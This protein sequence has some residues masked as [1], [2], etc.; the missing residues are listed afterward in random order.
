MDKFLVYYYY[1]YI[2][3][4]I[5]KDYRRLANLIQWNEEIV[6]QVKENS[7]FFFFNFFIVSDCYQWFG[8]VS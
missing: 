7:N 6:R 1:Y 8:L 3:L 2:Y 5:K 4:S